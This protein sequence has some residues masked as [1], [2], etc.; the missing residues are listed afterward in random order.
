[1][2]LRSTNS[3]IFS[4]ARSRDCFFARRRVT[5][6]LVGMMCLLS[7]L[8]SSAIAMPVPLSVVAQTGTSFNGANIDAFLMSGR[9]GFDLNNSG[10]VV[11][12]AFY[13]AGSGPFSGVGVFATSGFSAGPGSVIAGKTL[14]EANS[15][16]INNSGDIVF[17]G[18][19]SGGSGI[20][21]PSSSLA[22]TGDVIA[23]RTLT[24]P[25]EPS[26]NNNGDVAFRSKTGGVAF[27]IFTPTTG[28]V[29]LPVTIGGVPLGQIS[30]P[31]QL[32]DTGDVAFRADSFSV[33]FG[34]YTQSRRVMGNNTP[35]GSDTVSPFLNPGIS[36]TGDVAFLGSIAGLGTN[37]GLVVDSSSVLSIVARVG[38]TID[39]T[40]LTGF[41][42]IDPPSIN[43]SGEVAFVGMSAAGQAIFTQNRLIAERG[44]AFLGSTI[45]SFS[46]PVIN[47]L[48]DIAFYVRLANG[49]DALVITGEVPEPT[50]ASLFLLGLVSCLVPTSR[51]RY[52]SRRQ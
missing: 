7:A 2:I 52:R 26:L 37:T 19:Y 1:V 43:T 35:I 14:T 5:Q 22:Q 6:L 42:S 39:G 48:G 40:T 45:N 32:S 34:I 10:E 41:A 23:G 51:L 33:G 8:C 13:D 20:F 16:S 15:P 18:L 4:S 9:P 38:D 49:V 47:D 11:F 46:A 25:Q 27:S 31:A 17:A 21:T 50:S 12:G 24:G 44:D 28:L 30:G 36:P 3:A 29:V